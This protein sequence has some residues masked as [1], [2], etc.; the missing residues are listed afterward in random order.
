MYVLCSILQFRKLFQTL[1][2]KTQNDSDQS[3]E[4]PKGLGLTARPIDLFLEL[5]GKAT[6]HV[7]AVAGKNGVADA[8][9]TGVVIF[10]SQIIEIEGGFP[11]R[12][13]VENGRV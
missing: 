11:T 6:D 12:P 4:P 8:A 5:E 9:G 1:R 13:A 3:N 7:D 10:V 2:H